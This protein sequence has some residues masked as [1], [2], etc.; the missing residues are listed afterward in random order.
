[1]V[2]NKKILTTII[3]VASLIFITSCNVDNSGVLSV[4]TSNIV[5]SE[6]RPKDA[7]EDWWT[8]TRLTLNNL[9]IVQVDAKDIKNWCNDLNVAPACY[10]RQQ[11]VI[12]IRRINNEYDHEIFQDLGHE[13]WHAM[14]GRHK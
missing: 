9:D 14:G 3:S 5:T 8:P 10:N 11:N 4:T 6:T 2:L 1:M 13:V 7:H 12:V